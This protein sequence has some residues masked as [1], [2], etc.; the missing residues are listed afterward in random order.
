[1]RAEL[2]YGL[3]RPKI[4]NLPA[5]A[6]RITTRKTGHSTGPPPNAFMRTPC[7]RVMSEHPNCEQRTILEIAEAWSSATGEDATE[8]A[9]SLLSELEFGCFSFSIPRELPDYP[10]SGIADQLGRQ[11]RASAYF[12][13]EPLNSN[14]NHFRNVVPNVHCD[15]E[16]TRAISRSHGGSHRDG[17]PSTPLDIMEN[18]GST[19]VLGQPLAK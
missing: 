1:M 4:L 19:D 17:S 2:R 6:A 9:A 11:V 10:N 13:G 12:C 5:R 15:Q 3:G 18:T 8:L 7:G 16:K 14:D